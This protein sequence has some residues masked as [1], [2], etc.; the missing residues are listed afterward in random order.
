MR[1]LPFVLASLLLA[2]IGAAQQPTTRAEEIER[3]RRDKQARL[4]PERESPLV[5]QVNKL[6]ERGLYEGLESGKGANGVQIVMGGMRSGQ[7]VSVGVGYRR[8]DIW[9]DRFAMR[10]TA[11][12]TPL[13][14]YLFD[15]QLDFQSLQ[16]DWFFLDFYTKY[17]Y[18]PQ[19]DFYGQGGDSLEEARTSYV[20][21]DFATDFR[22]GFN[23]TDSLRAGFTIGGLAVHTGTGKRSGF[24]STDEIF[25]SETAPG[26]GENTNFARWGSFIELDYR[27]LPGGPRSG[28]YYTAVLR[29]YADQ[30]LGKY[31][32]SQVLV[33]AQQYIPYF[34][35][36]RVIAIRV[37]AAMAFEGDGQRVPF[38]LQP[39]LGGNDDLRGFARYRFY[40]NQSLYFNVEHR[41]HASST[42]DMAI[43]V[44]GGKVGPDVADIDFSDIKWSAGW[45]FV[46]RSR[47][48]TSC[49][50]T[51]RA[52][53]RASAS[54]GRSATFSRVE[55]RSTNESDV[56]LE[57]R[58]APRSGGAPL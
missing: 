44:D 33:Q 43:F 18:S 19:M 4:W 11:R 17:E 32:F 47:T 6:V 56:V 9:H 42:L 35:K 45:A 29:E 27:D 7:G 58:D 55:R 8:S 13:L 37:A 20:F 57:P 26:L 40:D 12:V 1:L 31:S 16:K 39:K 38:Y 10:G 54:C 3:Q 51:S 28:G 48:L 23:F 21:E 24:P 22:L 50:S 30:D 14:A 36:T 53:A 2:A 49:G 52:G 34:N 41:W 5:E 15:L 46:S 25:D